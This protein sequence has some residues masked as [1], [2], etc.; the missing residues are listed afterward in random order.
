MEKTHFDKDKRIKF[1]GAVYD[2][3]ILRR[4]RKNAKGYIHGHSAGGTNPSL[5]EA[6]SIT[7]VNILYDAVYNVEV[8]ESAALYFSKE[9]DSLKNA[10]E[11]VEKFKTK[12]N[13]EYSQLAKGRIAEE[14]TWEIV[15]KKYKKLFNKLLQK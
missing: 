9:E 3:E 6:L 2:D 15:V 12:E 1:V 13:N 11:K 8:G 14:Y 10:I 7:D 5:L 4:I